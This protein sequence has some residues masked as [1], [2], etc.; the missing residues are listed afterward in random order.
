MLLG[1]AVTSIVSTAIPKQQLFASPP[2]VDFQ[3]AVE[4][5]PE[6]ALK[7]V[8]CWLSQFDLLPGEHLECRVLAA[9]IHLMIHRLLRL[10]AG[11]DISEAPETRLLD[12]MLWILSVDWLYSHPESAWKILE[13]VIVDTPI[14][15]QDAIDLKYDQ[16]SSLVLDH[17]SDFVRGRNLASRIHVPSS[18]LQLLVTFITTQWSTL[19]TSTRT[20][21]ALRFL[22]LCLQQRFRPAYDVFHQRQ[23]LTFLAMQPVSSWSASLLKAYFIGIAAAIYPS[24]GNPEDNQMI[25]QAIDCLHEPENLFLVCSTLAMYTHRPVYGIAE[26]PDIMTA[27]AQIRPLDPAWGNCRQKLREWAED[28]NFFVGLEGEEPGIKKWRRNMRV[29]IKTLDIFFSNIP[30]QVTASLE[31]P[32]PPP[33]LQS[34]SW[35]D[36]VGRLLLWRRSRRQDEEHPLTE[37]VYTRST[38]IPTDALLP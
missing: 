24:R 13:S 18:A 10:A 19:H 6:I 15:S 38:H 29:A 26:K 8:M 23:C 2:V 25:S 21:A 28:E 12:S 22:T 34:E 1:S 11:T 16:C 5:F 3:Q 9:S 4:Y 31:L 33:Q 27:L 17:Y 14:F 36:R 20:N 37:G 32:G 35:L 7:Y 30:T